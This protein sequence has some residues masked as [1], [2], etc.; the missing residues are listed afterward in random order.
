MKQITY[1]KDGLEERLAG[2]PRESRPFSADQHAGVWKLPQTS[3]HL[4]KRVRSDVRTRFHV[5][6]LAGP[7]LGRQPWEHSHSLWS[8]STPTSQR[9]RGVKHCVEPSREEA[10]RLRTSALRSG[11]ITAR[12][13]IKWT[14]ICEDDTRPAA[15]RVPFTYFRHRNWERRFSELWSAK[16]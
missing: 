1:Q 3:P 14:L 7:F 6:L 16:L 9:K 10:S 4:R 12:L 5:K 13:Y 15:R 8:T 2:H 11:Q